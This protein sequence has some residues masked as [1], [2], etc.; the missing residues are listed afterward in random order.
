MGCSAGHVSRPAFSVPRY[1][2]SGDP[3]AF[4]ERSPFLLSDARSTPGNCVCWLCLTSFKYTFPSSLLHPSTSSSSPKSQCIS[5][6][7]LPFFSPY[8]SNQALPTHHLLPTTKIT[9]TITP[10]ALQSIRTLTSNIQQEL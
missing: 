8:S 4:G 6:P 1:W 7:P 2:E 10:T 3:E 9:F 5:L